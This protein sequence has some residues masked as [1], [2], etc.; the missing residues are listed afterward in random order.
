MTYASLQITKLVILLLFVAHLQ[1]VLNKESATSRTRVTV[2][3]SF[4]AAEEVGGRLIYGPRV[5][6]TS[7]PTL[8]TSLPWGQGL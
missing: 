1:V 3:L 7:W 4:T 8:F 5:P 6:V 2:L